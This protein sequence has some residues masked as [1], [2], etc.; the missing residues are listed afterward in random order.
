MSGPSTRR[1]LVVGA[2]VM[3]AWTALHARRAGWDVTLLDA[4][5]VGHPRATSSDETRVTRA[6]HGGDELYT[7]WSRRALDQWKALGDEVGERLFV[8]AGVLWLA[9][10]DD[11]FEAASE[12]TLRRLGVP[13]ERMSADDIPRRWPGISGA[14][15]AFALF[16]PEAGALMARRGLQAAVRAFVAEGGRFELAAVRPPAGSAAGA[17]AS[18]AVLRAVTSEDGRTWSGDGFV[19]AAGPWLPWLFPELLVGLVSVTK[20]DVVFIGP[21]PG[22]ERYRAGRCPLWCEF[23]WPSWGVPAID[24]RGFKVAYDI[25]GPPFDPTNGERIVDRASVQQVRAIIER[26]FPGLAGAPVVETRVCQYEAT[27]DTNF[28]LDRHPEL[29]NVWIAG[30]GS[31]HAFKH[32]PVIGEYLAG[33]L[34]GRTPEQQEG[35]AA[36]RFRLGPRQPGPGVRTAGH[37]LGATPG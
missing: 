10:R 3:G 22:D 31:G 30:G 11:G 33:I 17:V 36:D 6:A 26:R 16:E 2:G 4:W 14:G 27:P 25:Y 15:L 32:G 18:D 13:V 9:Q 7:R 34:E 12:P 28:I 37:S 1:L 5:G 23:D 20:Q 24:D 21:A 35:E 19:F 29:G 8:E